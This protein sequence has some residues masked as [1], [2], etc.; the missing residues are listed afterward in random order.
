MADLRAVVNALGVRGGLHIRDRIWFIDALGS[1][2]GAAVAGTM[3]ITTLLGMVLAASRWRLVDWQWLS[4][5]PLVLMD[6]MYTIANLP[7]SCRAHGCRCC[8]ASLLSACS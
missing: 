1:A 7:S 6:G 4:F 8:S 3:G 5:G 2:Y